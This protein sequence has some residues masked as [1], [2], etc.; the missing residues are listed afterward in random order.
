MSGGASRR[1]SLV[2]VLTAAVVAAWLGGGLG[3][4]ARADAAGSRVAAGPPPVPLILDT[5][6]FSSVD[7]AEALALAFDFEQNGEARLL[8]V[9]LNTRTINGQR[10][11]A[12]DSWRCVAAIDA[13][14][15][16]A[17]VPI[18]TQT[19]LGEPPPNSPDFVGPCGGLAPATAPPPAPAV[20]VDRAALASQPNDSVVMVTT[21]YE[22]NLAALLQSPADAEGPPG[23]QLVAEKVRVLVVMGGGYPSYSEENNFYGDP[24]DAQYVA[25]NWPTKIVYSGQEIGTAVHT[26]S[27]LA[28]THPP[29]SPLRVAYDAFVGPGKWY[30]AYDPAAMYH[31]VRPRD[32]LLKEVGPGINTIDANGNNSFAL[33]GGDRYY[34]TAAEPARLAAAINAL[35]DTLPPTPSRI[36]TWMLSA[37][38]SSGSHVRF[39]NLLTRRGDVCS[40]PAS[41]S[42]RLVMQWYRRAGRRTGRPLATGAVVIRG[43]GSVRVRIRVTAAGRRLFRNAR[44]LRLTATARF[45]PRTGGSVA[46]TRAVIV[47]R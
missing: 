46:V 42:G 47:R 43:P 33:G 1:A 16:H 38:H 10:P 40:V 39:R 15:G 28:R 5:D 12:T 20:S 9:T 26:G 23:A 4:T 3:V 8:A 22:G 7:D 13:F 18:G 24:S 25:A 44:R 34:L 17:D 11:V 35:L 29:N 2:A 30:F 32:P 19:P 41:W 14:Y 37:I 6:I 45:T 21:G 31:A 36:R 27:M